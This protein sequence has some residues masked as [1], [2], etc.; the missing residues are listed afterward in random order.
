MRR[1]IFMKDSF[2]ITKAGSGDTVIDVVPLSEIIEIN[3]MSTD[4]LKGK[5]T[6]SRNSFSFMTAI[7]TTSSENNVGE[8]I[9]SDE[10]SPKCGE[11]ARKG[12]QQSIFHINTIPDGFNLGRTYY[13]QV[14][15]EQRC[16]TIIAEITVLT[17]AAR[18]RAD[19]SSRWK[20]AQDMVRSVQTALPFQ[21]CMVALILTV[22]R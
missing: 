19:R 2:Y 9:A 21:M 12:H 15:S 5:P 8:S 20:K 22:R 14:A 13:F 16:R 10:F 7:N 4:G 18:K 11:L 17:E 1:C 6:T 3:E